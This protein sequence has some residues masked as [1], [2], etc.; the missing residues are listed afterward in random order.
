MAGTG[1]AA[2]R[3]SV[4][5]RRREGL[6]RAGATGSA[7]VP[8]R[9]HARLRCTCSD[10]NLPFYSAAGRLG[11]PEAPVFFSSTPPDLGL[12]LRADAR[13]HLRVAFRAARRVVRERR[14]RRVGEG[15]NVR[16][17]ASALRMSR[18][19]K[20]PCRPRAGSRPMSIP[21]PRPSALR[22]TPPAPSELRAG[23]VTALIP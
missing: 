18:V 16:P 11:P 12:A 8:S 20:P 15:R 22:G 10:I 6:R 9:Q 19:A 7:S 14:L 23:G 3:R 2:W 4:T 17:A 5:E 21:R 13:A 1:G